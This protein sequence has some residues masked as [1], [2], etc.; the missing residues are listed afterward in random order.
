MQASDGWLHRFK[1]RYG[2]K[3]LSLKGEILSNDNKSVEQ[4]VKLLNAKIMEENLN[5][6]N[7]YNADESG[8]YWKILL[9]YTSLLTEEN[10]G[11][12]F[13]ANQ[14]RSTA[15]FCANATGSHRIPLLIIDD[16]AKPR[17]LKHLIDR[18]AKLNDINYLPELDVTYTAQK[19]G[20]MNCETFKNW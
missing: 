7:V 18:E 8:I 10:V 12:G 2:L 14:D 5:L 4:F 19:S 15:L 9:N 11:V 3:K 6:E 17:D 13:K 16:S 1:K 20:W